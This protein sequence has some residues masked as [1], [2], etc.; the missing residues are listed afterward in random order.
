MGRA[1][2]RTKA[3]LGTGARLADY[4]SASP[5]ARVGPAEVVNEVLDVHGRNSQRL[6]SFPAVVGV[7]YCIALNL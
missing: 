3:M 2:A 4:L 6:R 5:L 1:M 7:N